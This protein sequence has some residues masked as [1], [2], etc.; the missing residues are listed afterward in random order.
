MFQNVS[1][2]L[3]LIASAAVQWL[4]YRERLPKDFKPKRIL[5]VKLDH[6]GDVVLATPVFSNLRRA[7]P[8][9]E[10]HALTGTWSRVVLEKHPDVNKVLEYNSPTFCRTGQ[11]TPLKEVFQLYQ[12]L[13]HQKYD[14][15]VE[16]RGDW[17]IVCFALLRITPKR[18]DRAALQNCEQVGFCTILRD[19]R[20]DP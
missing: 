5:V 19:T 12:Q 9:A 18:L 8:N 15:L 14:L 20:G 17:R 4:C 2:T 3:T 6:L 7:Y 10:L 11:P 1:E 13:R 16:L